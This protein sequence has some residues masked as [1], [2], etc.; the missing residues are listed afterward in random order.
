VTIYVDSKA[1]PPVAA[2]NAIQEGSTKTVNFANGST[3]DEEA[4]TTIEKYIWDFDVNTDSS[5]D[6]K[7]D[8][9]IDSSEENPLNEYANF[10]IYRAKLTVTDNQGISNSVTNFVNVKGTA[11]S[12]ADVLDA[13]I[14]TTPAPSFLDGKV[15][16]T[17]ESKDVTLDFSSSVGD[18]IVKYAIDKNIYYD[19]N[20]NANP[21]D[22]E[23]FIATEPG[24][25]TTSFSRS[26]G[27]VKVRLTVTDSNG[28]KDT[29]DKEI[30]FDE[31]TGNI[32]S[33]D[34]MS[35][36]AGSAAALI[37]SAVGFAILLIRKKIIKQK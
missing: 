32:F 24:E 18:K 26:Y 5:G 7:K 35:A 2:F 3:A 13:R 21:A 1:K 15:H 4:G 28:K 16:L 8:N 10:G 37:V 31:I 19:T 34:V 25:W 22:D 20:G 36:S 27:A 23:N 30:V 12:S 29:V 17:G 11:V 33:A 6:G 9:D 14:L